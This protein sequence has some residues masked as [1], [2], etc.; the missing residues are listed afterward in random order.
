MAGGAVGVVAA[1]AEALSAWRSAVGGF[2][3]GI[4]LFDAE[5]FGIAPGRR[6]WSIRSSG[7]WSTAFAACEAAGYSRRGG[8]DSRSRCSWRGQEPVRRAVRRTAGHGRLG[9][10]GHRGSML[11]NRASYLL[12]LAGPSLAVNAACSSSLVALHLACQ[13]LQGGECDLAL[14]GGVNMLLDPRHDARRPRRISRRA[15]GTS[16]RLTTRPTA[17]CQAKASPCVLLNRSRRPSRR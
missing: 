7:C 13:S 15:T 5:L 9:A 6:N 14:A 11:A 3:E 16:R 12:N 1:G 2:I 4:E 8:R 10:D 17:A